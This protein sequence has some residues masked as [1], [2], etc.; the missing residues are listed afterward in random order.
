MQCIPVYLGRFLWKV[1]MEGVCVPQMTWA[2]RNVFCRVTSL[3]SLIFH[4]DSMW[5]EHIDSRGEKVKEKGV[6]M[7]KIRLIHVRF[8][9]NTTQ[10]CVCIPLHQHFSCNPNFDCKFSY[11]QWQG[12]RIYYFFHYVLFFIYCNHNQKTRGLTLQYSPV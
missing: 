2:E 8:M 11:C 5:T 4:A 1:K 9:R 10:I 3:S 6:G 12:E 7:L